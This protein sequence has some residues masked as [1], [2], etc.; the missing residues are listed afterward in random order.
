[1]LVA[2]LIAA[3][4]AAAVHVYIFY[5]EAFAWTR[6]RTRS[7][8]GTSEQEAVTTRPLA[9][10]QGFYNLFLAIGTVI[11]IVVIA[12]ASEPVGSGLVLLATGSMLAAAIVLAGSDP[13]KARAAAVQGAFPL[14]AVVLL[15]IH[16]AG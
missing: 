15:L 12:A 14:I 9:F 11:G 3:G 10:N 16:L 2:G 5:L 6:P 4:L 1:M 7:T 13:T 8:F